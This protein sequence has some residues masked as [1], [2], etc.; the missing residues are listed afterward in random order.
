MIIHEIKNRPILVCLI[1]LLFLS[2]P[3]YA[4]NL[5][6][7]PTFNLVSSGYGA[8]A[9][10]LGGAFVAVADDLTT[11]YWNPAGLGQLE[12]IQFHGDYRFQTDSHEDFAAEVQPNVFQSDQHY[13][14][15]GN[16]LQSLS[17]SY[18]IL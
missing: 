18:A 15:K 13:T 4:Q 14:I 11:I 1:V 8:K 5:E 16:Q 12:G 7:A 17:V 2:L 6:P 9:L 10:G 3:L